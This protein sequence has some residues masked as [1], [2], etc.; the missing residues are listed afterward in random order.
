MT[1][2]AD[3]DQL[4]VITTVLPTRAGQASYG[5]AVERVLNYLKKN[6]PENA[7]IDEFCPTVKC[8]NV[9][10]LTVAIRVI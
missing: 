3:W 6:C 4:K 8:I 2:R 5:R 9:I 7:A 10:F 1:M